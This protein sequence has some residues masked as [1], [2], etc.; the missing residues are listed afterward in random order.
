MR[1]TRADGVE[2]EL[3]DDGTWKYSQSAET[4]D[5][6]VIE[7]PPDASAENG[8]RG[9]PWGSSS[10]AAKAREGREP[11]EHQDGFYAWNGIALAGLTWSALY[12]LV[13]DRLARGTYLLAGEFQNKNRYLVEYQSVLDLLTQKYGEPTQKDDVWFA[14]TYQ[15]VPNEWGM[16]VAVGDYARYAK[17]IFDESEVMLTVRGEDFDIN[18]TV[19]YSSRELAAE[20]D[21]RQNVQDLSAL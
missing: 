1:A 2:V 3:H 17:W 14:E 15:D 21:R 5:D 19:A 8:F 4:G 13:D 12:S 11:D 7:R 16:A 18:L 9:V 6:D 20:E 10:T